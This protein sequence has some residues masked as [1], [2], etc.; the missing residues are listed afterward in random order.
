[1]PVRPHPPTGGS[2]ER[3]ALSIPKANALRLCNLT[4][5][6]DEPGDLS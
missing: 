2:P 5:S 6:S 4:E 1:M 3:A